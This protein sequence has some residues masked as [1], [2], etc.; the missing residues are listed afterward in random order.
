MRSVKRTIK[1]SAAHDILAQVNSNVRDVV[2]D[3]VHDP[4]WVGMG[5][6]WMVMRDHVRENFR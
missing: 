1:V 3:Q 6:V 4:L 2:M 5:R